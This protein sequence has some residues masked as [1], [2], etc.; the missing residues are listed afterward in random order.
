[1]ENG[2]QT[3]LNEAI[4]EF[5][6]FMN[7]GPQPGSDFAPTLHPYFFG[8]VVAERLRVLAFAI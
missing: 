4:R 7:S 2:A 3:A 1:M 8:P 6:S 5:R